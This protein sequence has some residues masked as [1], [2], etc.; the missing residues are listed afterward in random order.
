MVQTIKPDAY[1]KIG[2][3]GNK[4]VEIDWFELKLNKVNRF[5]LI[6]YLFKAIFFLR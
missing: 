3:K 2:L 1:L 6:K 4:V 5:I